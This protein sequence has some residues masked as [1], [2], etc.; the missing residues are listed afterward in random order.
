M[1][2]RRVCP[3]DCQQGGAGGVVMA[4]RAIWLVVVTTALVGAPPAMGGGATRFTYVAGAAGWT[5]A[6]ELV[7]G[8]NPPAGAAPYG[9]LRITP[10][11]RSIA[12]T[13]DDIGAL[14]GQT[15]AVWVSGIGYR[16]LPVRERTS[17][18]GLTPGR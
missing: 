6:D 16:C 7:L 2:L 1:R 18:A 17:I 12:V 15:V 3:R 14:D 10:Q 9:I 4:A 13:L 5:D 11:H 8:E